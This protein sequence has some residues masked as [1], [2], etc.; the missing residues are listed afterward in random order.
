MEISEENLYVD[1]GAKRVKQV[2]TDT[3]HPAYKNL[4][5][6]WQKFATLIPKNTRTCLTKQDQTGSY[7]W[8]SV[9]LCKTS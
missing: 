6:S 5:D 3:V 4:V 7:L 9:K 8:V 2:P 1:I